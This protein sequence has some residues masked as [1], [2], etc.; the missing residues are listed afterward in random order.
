MASG[1][2]E[3]TEDKTCSQ[4]CDFRCY[5][6]KIKKCTKRNRG[7]NKRRTK[8]HR[9][10]DEFHKMPHVC[11][12]C[13]NRPP[14]TPDAEDETCTQAC[15][16][17]CF[18]CKIRRCTKTNRATNEFHKMPHACGPCG[19]RPPPTPD[20]R[21]AIGNGRTTRTKM[22][23]ASRSISPS[24]IDTPDFESYRQRRLEQALD[25][26]VARGTGPHPTHTAT[27]AAQFRDAADKYGGMKSEEMF[28]GTETLD[29][30]PMPIVNQVIKKQ[31]ADRAAAGLLPL[32][33]VDGRLPNLDE[34]LE[35]IQGPMYMP[36]GNKP[37]RSPR[38][39]YCDLCMHNYLPGLCFCSGG[40]DDD[41]DAEGKESA[42]TNEADHEPWR[43]N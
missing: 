2:S 27:P 11:G 36:C 20:G 42:M 17:R 7:C 35:N 30:P 12:L 6:C 34:A 10:E 25:P 1:H 43:Y 8:T 37:P 18:W 9:A 5:W 16:F 40:D 13:G 28:N 31:A 22:V 24:A 33:S 29:R 4:A 15:N 23:T 38:R 39:I 32:P 3:D 41:N 26:A 14:P 19:N 21:P